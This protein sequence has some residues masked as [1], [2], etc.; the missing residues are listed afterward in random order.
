MNAPEAWKYLIRQALIVKAEGKRFTTNSGRYHWVHSAS[1]EELAIGR[2]ERGSSIVEGKPS[3]LNFPSFEKGWNL[4]NQYGSID[5]NDLPRG[6][7]VQ[8]FLV[9][10]LMSDVLIYNESTKT[11]QLK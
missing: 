6:V 9:R 3:T 2:H 10:T 11:L 8:Q 1:E 4:L 5:S 7:T